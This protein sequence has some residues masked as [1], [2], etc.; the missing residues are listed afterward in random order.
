[1]MDPDQL[2]SAREVDQKLIIQMAVWDRLRMT[3][4][5]SLAKEIMGAC[6]LL[7]ISHRQPLKTK[8]KKL[9]SQNN[10]GM[11]GEVLGMMSFDRLRTS[12]ES[13]VE[14]SRRGDD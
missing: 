2:R 4:R 3:I 11:A 10:F 13:W 12:Q 9:V 5:D 14:N 6:F 1:M 8:I 7:S